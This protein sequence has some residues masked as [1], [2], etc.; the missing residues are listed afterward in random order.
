VGAAEAHVVEAAAVAQADFAGAINA[1][2]ADAVMTVG[3]A[4]RPAACG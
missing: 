1:V 4:D 2:G 3:A